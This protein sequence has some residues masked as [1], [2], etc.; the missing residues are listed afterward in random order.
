[1]AYIASKCGVPVYPVGISYKGHLCFR[2]KITVT[3][4]KPISPEELKINNLT[5]TELRAAGERVMSRI[6][7]L[8][9]S[10]G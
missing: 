8:V 9:E 10:N 3:F 7:E 1:M 4:G 5:K 2:R 6:A